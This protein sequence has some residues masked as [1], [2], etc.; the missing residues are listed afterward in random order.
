MR[1]VRFILGLS[2]SLFLSSCTVSSNDRGLLSNISIR[3]FE[4]VGVRLFESGEQFA[5][6]DVHLDGAG[7]LNRDVFVTGKVEVVG[8]FGTFIVISEDQIRMLI[9][10][11]HL[12]GLNT[13]VVK[14]D[15]MKVIGKVQ[16]GE[17]GHFYLVANAV[18]RG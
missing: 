13:P 8:A 7:L 9:D 12:G 3:I 17:K 5:L 16:S 14:G 15:T 6:K 18:S 1:Q 11:S 4:W 2:I 10:L